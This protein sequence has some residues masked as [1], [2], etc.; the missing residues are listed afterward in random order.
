MKHYIIVTFDGAAKDLKRHCHDRR[1]ALQALRENPGAR[2]MVFSSEDEVSCFLSTP[3]ATNGHVTDHDRALQYMQAAAYDGRYKQCFLQAIEAG[4]DLQVFRMIVCAP[5]LLINDTNHPRVYNKAGENALHIAAR[6]G[7]AQICTHILEAI[8]TPAFIAGYQGKRT[9]MTDVLSE[10][11]LELYLNSVDRYKYE[12]PLHLAAQHGWVSVVRVLLSYPQCELKPNIW[13]HYPQHV[14]CVRA[15]GAST[16][17]AVMVAITGLLQENYFVPLVRTESDLEPPFVGEAFMRQKPPDLS[18]PS[19]DVLAPGRSIAAFAGPMTLEQAHH[20]RKLWQTTPRLSVIAIQGGG[21]NYSP[22]TGSDSRLLCAVT[23]KIYEKSNLSQSPGFIMREFRRR[24]LHA[25]MERI[26][27]Y[28]AKWMN[29]R[30]KEYWPFLS[31]YCDLGELVGLHIFETYLA[32]RA[33]N[34]TMQQTASSIAIGGVITNRDNLFALFALEN[35][36]INEQLF[37]FVMRWKRNMLL[38]FNADK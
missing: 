26:G 4:D 12:T 15:T 27:R 28:L 13:K 34:L 24:Y 37:P 14:I 19:Q 21:P 11:L 32:Q 33:A 6:C 30:W 9:E 3:P 2:M 25:A 7:F 17:S 36:E 1:E 10:K 5:A 20:F 23:G 22:Q 18:H 16:S 35:V 31:V 38:I 8:R 29:V